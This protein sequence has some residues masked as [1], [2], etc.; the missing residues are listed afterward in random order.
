LCFSV[1][2][3]ST[4]FSMVDHGIH[5]WQPDT[6]HKV[7]RSSV[8][9]I[10]GRSEKVGCTKRRCATVSIAHLGFRPH[11]EDYTA[12]EPTAATEHS[13]PSDL[14]RENDGLGAPGVDDFGP[15]TR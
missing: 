11:A 6:T 8:R 13:G 7:R 5:Y 3:F 9:H 12:E 4:S 10:T 15:P 14:G 2:S 1:A